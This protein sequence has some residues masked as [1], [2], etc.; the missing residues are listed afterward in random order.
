MDANSNDAIKLIDR[1]TLSALQR[2]AATSPRRRMHLNFHTSMAESVQRLVVAI[3]PDSYIRPHRHV[4]PPKWEF[5]LVINGA[6]S[7]LLFDDYGTVERRLDMGRGGPVFGYEIPPGVWHT[8][9]ALESNT[10]FAEVKMGPYA[11]IADQDFAA[12]APMEGD[13]ACAKFTRWFYTAEPGST[14]PAVSQ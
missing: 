7:L 4:Q 12:W 9:V 11:P 1:E 5:F 14:P 8:V 2:D 10:V 13:H 3:E 6:V